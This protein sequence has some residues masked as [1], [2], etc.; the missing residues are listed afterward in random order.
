M[1]A[2]RRAGGGR[3]LVGATATAAALGGIVAVAVAAAAIARLGAGCRFVDAQRGRAAAVLDRVG[4]RAAPAVNLLF[5]VAA[6]GQ[7]GQIFLVERSR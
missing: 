5:E 2:A 7:V 6:A 4:S 3:S 1:K